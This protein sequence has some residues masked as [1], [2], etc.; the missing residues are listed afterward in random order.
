MVSYNKICGNLYFE[1]VE[2]ANM[3]IYRWFDGNITVCTIGFNWLCVALLHGVNDNL[4]ISIK[5]P[6]ISHVSFAIYSWTLNNHRQGQS[7]SIIV[8]TF[9]VHSCTSTQ[10]RSHFFGSTFDETNSQTTQ[11]NKKTQPKPLHDNDCFC[12]SIIILLYCFHWVRKKKTTPLSCLPA[13]CFWWICLTISF[14]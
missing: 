6:L 10:V 3:L 1:C 2:F 11:H 4:E 5:A 13:T 7:R 8:Y 14:K 12:S 9:L